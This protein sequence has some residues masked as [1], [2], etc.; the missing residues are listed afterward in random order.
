MG[1]LL[2][3][4][5]ARE[6]SD[7]VVLEVGIGTPMLRHVEDGVQGWDVKDAEEWLRMLG[8]EGGSSCLEFL[9]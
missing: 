5:H 3:E 9:R 4:V 7:R 1:F 6:I 8:A 2:R